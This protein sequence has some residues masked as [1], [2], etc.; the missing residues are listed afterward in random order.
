[1]SIPRFLVLFAAIALT[2]SAR[3]GLAGTTSATM[4]RPSEEQT[5]APVEDAADQ[6]PEGGPPRKGKGKAPRSPLP[7]QGGPPRKGKGKG[8]LPPLPP[9]GPKEPPAWKL[10]LER[11]NAHERALEE[12]REQRRSSEFPPIRVRVLML[13]VH[14]IPCATQAQRDAALTQLRNAVTEVPNALSELDAV[15][16]PENYLAHWQC[17]LFCPDSSDIFVQQVGELAREFAVTIVLG[18]GKEYTGPHRCALIEE[19]RRVHENLDLRSA[20]EGGRGSPRAVGENEETLQKRRYWRTS[21]VIGPSGKLLETVSKLPNIRQAVA[22]DDEQGW[23]NGF[24][25]RKRA[26]HNVERE[27]TGDSVGLF[28]L[29]PKSLRHTSDHKVEITCG[30]LICLDIEEGP[31]LD[32]TLQ[33]GAQLIFNPIKI[34][35]DE[36]VWR[37]QEQ[38][39]ITFSS[40]PAV[41]G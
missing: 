6:I 8:P 19:D 23:D 26:I 22:G 15:V 31:L 33:A 36:H 12:V 13:Q 29:R 5:A 11:K 39:S 40:S 37:T 7:P 30:V 2:T 21:L 9:Q 17:P 18:S 34:S 14:A 10:A 25:Y 4:G 24:H 35:P 3:T 1:M 20:E 38:V 28:P 27:L 41:R 16:L 32:E